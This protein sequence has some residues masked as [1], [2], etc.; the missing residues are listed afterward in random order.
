[1]KVVRNNTPNADSNFPMDSKF[2]NQ[3]KFLGFFLNDKPLFSE[4]I[5]LVTSACYYVLQIVYSIRD[6]V[7]SDVLVELVG[8]MII[9]LPDYCNSFIYRLPAVFQG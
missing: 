3:V 9:S 5:S 2:L 4:Q 7:D 8:V 1:M 6:T